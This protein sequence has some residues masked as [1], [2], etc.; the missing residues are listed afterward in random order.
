MS[1]DNYTPSD[2][3][4]MTDY[5]NMQ[6]LVADE[7]DTEANYQALMRWQRWLASVRADAWD[8]AMSA[9]EEVDGPNYLPNPYRSE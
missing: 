8:E 7:K 4:V 6:S 5:L 3:E 9:A 2:D 1:D